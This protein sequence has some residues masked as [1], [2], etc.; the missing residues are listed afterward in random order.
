MQEFSGRYKATLVITPDTTLVPSAPLSTP[1]PSSDGTPPFRGG[2]VLR[3][4]VLLY[5]KT[6][7]RSSDSQDESVC[8]AR[9]HVSG[10]LLVWLLDRHGACYVTT[11]SSSYPLRTRHPCPLTGVLGVETPGTLESSAKPTT[12]SRY[13]LHRRPRHEDSYDCY[14]PGPSSASSSLPVPVTA[15]D[16]HEPPPPPPTRSSTHSSL[17]LPGFPP[18]T[19]VSGRQSLQL[20]LGSRSDPGDEPPSFHSLLPTPT[21]VVKSFLSSSALCHHVRPS[22]MSFL[23]VTVG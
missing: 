19:D 7:T 14:Y 13:L 11:T 10:P 4:D 17:A 3:G 5:G 12:V 21:W 22:F 8:R 16:R 23:L 20:H 2:W 1:T 15:P 18:T 6:D 9:F